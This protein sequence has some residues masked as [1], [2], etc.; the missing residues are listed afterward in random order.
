MAAARS[1]PLRAFNHSRGVPM[2]RPS[3]R[4]RLGLVVVTGVAL[5]ASAAAAGAQDPPIAG[6]TAEHA[7]R[8]SAYEDAFTRGVSPDNIGRTSRRLSR[9]PHLVGTA[10]DRRAERISVDTLRSYGLHV[11]TPGYSVYSSRPEKISVTMTAPYTRS[12]ATK[13]RGFP[14]QEGF[15]DV[16]EGYNAFSPSGHVA[17]DVV[18]ANYGLP[19]D[20]AALE[21]LGVSVAGKIVLVRYGRSFRGV[22]AQQAEL[23][24]ARGLIIYSDPEDDGF[25]RG[26]VYPDGPW[27]P[28]DAI[29]RGSI[30]YI[31]NYPGDPLTPGAPALPGTPRIAP[32]DADNLPSIPTTPISYGEARPL[33]ESLSGPEAPDDFKGGLPI[34]YRV[35]P[36][37]T[38]VRLDLDIA[39]EQTPVSNVIAR[40]RGTTKPDEKVVVGAHYDAWTY[41]G[42]DNTSGWA[43]VM[44]VGHSLGRLL[45]R[46]WRPE[47]TIVLAG[48]DGE[49]YG[50]FGSTEWAEQFEADLRRNAVAYANLDGAGGPKFQASGVPQLDDA[51]I[52][53]TKA[54]SDPHTG[55]SVFD[56]WTDGGSRAPAIDRLGSGSDYTAFLDHIGVPSLEAGFT[57]D[58]SAGTY[59][60]AY[61][62]TYN[63]EHH[64]DPGYL[65]NAGSSL[66][67]GVSALRLANADIVPFHHSDYAAAVASYVR[68][69]QAVQQNTPGAAQVDLGVLLDAAEA[70]RG[71]STALEATVDQLLAGDVLDGR[72]G[73]R[74]A[75]RIN[76][77][78][79]RQERALTTRE[80]LPGRP[81]F[82]HQ[83]YAPGLVTGY[84]VQYLPGLRDAV[85][86]GD[87]ETA[88][89][90]RDLL[91]DS[92]LRAA[93]I[94]QQGAAAR[95]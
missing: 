23:R 10:G 81:W 5:G 50:L 49:E 80:G 17:G 57:N 32:A 11:T 46:G 59:H 34:T 68:D 69:L 52:E 41:G 25:T 44:E 61:D 77:A 16:V 36:G 22:K 53:V 7:A 35:G 19:E 40:I 63:M 24:G 75:R 4:R 62:D 65:G 93:R 51:L 9:R 55:R 14:W 74:A 42:S 2:S 56:T 39:Y 83:I 31:F 3:M 45:A 76:R 86:Q 94:A 72:R 1:A 33:L 78:L 26:P 48:W 37:G 8:Q 20:Y 38:R 18:Y 28:A 87:V 21:A 88:T 70:W 60:S 66:V 47:R 95:I 29:Q 85:E 6:F 13:E 89:K 15:D 73:A 30:Q 58:A 64:L 84:A 71:A 43:A 54:V 67:T 12:L 91:L 92:L 90:Y 79:F 27:R 82:R